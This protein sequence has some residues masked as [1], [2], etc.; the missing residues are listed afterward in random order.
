M[1]VGR[2]TALAEKTRSHL[3]VLECVIES[4]K[5]RQRIR[6]RGLT[7]DHVKLTDEGWAHFT[8][9]D[10]LG[11]RNPLSHVTID[12]SQA[13]EACL[14]IALSLIIPRRARRWSCL[15]RSLESL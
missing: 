8:R 13:P 9:T 6:E 3:Q 2:I 5:L 7:R 11:D 12:M 4:E 14:A 10:R 1:T 15:Q